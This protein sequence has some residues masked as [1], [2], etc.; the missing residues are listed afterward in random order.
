[1]PII[2]PGR[3]TPGPVSPTTCVPLI[4]AH[5]TKD[6]TIALHQAGTMGAEVLVHALA[7]AVNR[8]A[9]RALGRTDG[10]S[11]KDLTSVGQVDARPRFDGQHGNRPEFRRE[12]SNRS[13]NYLDETSR[14]FTQSA[15]AGW[16][17]PMATFT[18][19]VGTVPNSPACCSLKVSA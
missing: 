16:A 11:G 12:G 10:L 13:K 17:A 7:Q 4:M 14:S 15:V 6:E 2:R 1:M 8:H 5:G 19:T 18:G 9:R 3:A